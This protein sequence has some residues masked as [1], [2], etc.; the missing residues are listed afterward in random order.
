MDAE[1]ECNEIILNTQCGT[2]RKYYIHARNV[3]K[4]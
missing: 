1:Q 3:V 4:Y 2:E